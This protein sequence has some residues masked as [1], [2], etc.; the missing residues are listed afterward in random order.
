M[1]ETRSRAQRKEQTRQRLLDV[2]LGLITDRSLAGLSLREVARAAGIVPTAFYRHYASMDALGVDL[3]DECMR[4]L[5]QLLRQARRGRV[6][7]GDI[8]GETVDILAAQVRASP[9][10][11]RFLTRERYG[12]VAAVRRA[13]D[14]E[15][16]LFTSDLTVDLARLTAGFD[17]TAEDLEM[18]ADLMVTAM[19]GTVLALLEAD[20]R[21]PDEVAA[22]LD[23]AQRQLRLIVLGMGAWR[24]KP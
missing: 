22:R 17:W 23:V 16:R 14:V 8:I 11:F 15:L 10:Q 20:D 2:T 7:H 12:G 21:R 19:L 24:S 9:D 4:P 6:T 13:I 5:R 3:V 18:T 1:T